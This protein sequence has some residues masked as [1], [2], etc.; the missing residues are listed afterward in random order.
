MKFENIQVISWDIYS[1]NHSIEKNLS[2][3]IMIP[4]YIME[5]CLNNK[6]DI[7]N[8]ILFIEIKDMNDNKITQMSN[9]LVFGN[10]E[11]TDANVCVLPFWAMSKLKLLEFG[12]VSIENAN[13]IK[14]IGF[15]KLKANISN[16]VYWEDIKKILENELENYRCLSVEDVICIA[17]VEFYV[18]ELRDTDSIIISNGSLFNTEP[19]I[20]FD[21]PTD[22]EYLELLNN[23]T[24]EN[25]QTYVP[26][27]IEELEKDDNSKKPA[28]SYTLT[29]HTGAEIKILEKHY[30]EQK[31]MSTNKNKKN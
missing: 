30:A 24:L 19:S 31:L 13:F 28:L 2:H 12:K 21:V 16:Y 3:S 6:T 20:E 5:S 23:T 17:D 29:F 4:N 14:K 18:T 26:R 10:I 27:T 7:D 11:V 8:P 9:S 25:Q 22:I 1:D 15:I